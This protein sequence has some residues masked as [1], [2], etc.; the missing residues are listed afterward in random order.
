[1]RREWSSVKLTVSAADVKDVSR[2]LRRCIQNQPVI[3][4]MAGIKLEAV[5]DELTITATDGD[6]TAVASVRAEVDREGAAVV[7]GKQFISLASELEG[8]MSMEHREKILEVWCGAGEY[9]FDA[10]PPD[11]FPVTPDEPVGD[12]FIVEDI[13]RIAFAADS[14]SPYGA[15][16]CVCFN[17]GEIIAADTVRMAIEKGLPFAGKSL[18]PASA[19]EGLVG[20]SVTLGPKVVKF[21]KGNVRLMVVVAD[22]EFVKYQHITGSARFSVTA[23]VEKDA[24]LAA[25]RRLGAVESLWVGV[26]VSPSSVRLVGENDQGIKGYEVLS[27]DATGEA[28]VMFDIKLLDEGVDHVPGATFT[29]RLAGPR[30][31]SVLES[32]DWSYWLLP[33]AHNV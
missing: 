20:Y 21:A 23:S 33:V 10:L 11:G 16:T 2:V 32:D 18:V 8:N 30:D 6:K 17:D 9:K 5:G 24:M 22:F 26:E 19:V 4:I 29:W 7:N 28:K 15:L 12:S 14:K 25:L 13:G 31:I 3:P 27:C 1:M